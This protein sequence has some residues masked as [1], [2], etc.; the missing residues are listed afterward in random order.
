MKYALRIRIEAEDDIREAYLWYEARRDGLGDDFLLCLEAA[1]ELIQ[2]SPS[3]YPTIDQGVRRILVR[4]FPFAVLYLIQGDTII[5][6][7]I[8]HCH[9]N[10]RTW[11][12][13]LNG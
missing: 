1:F 12:M 5:V 6:F 8:F 2:E 7:A 11:R 9:R 13:R 10:P 4:R 3:R